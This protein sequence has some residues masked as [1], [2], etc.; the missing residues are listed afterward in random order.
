[1][2]IPPGILYGIVAGNCEPGLCVFRLTKR[3]LLE[4]DTHSYN[5]YPCIIYILYHYIHAATPPAPRCITGLVQNKFRERG[6]ME[7]CQLVL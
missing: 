7:Q 4:I 1:M 2:S 3:D 5:V 6:S